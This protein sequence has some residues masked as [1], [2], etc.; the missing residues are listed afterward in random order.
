MAIKDA[1]IA[2]LK[3]EASL[4]KKNAGKSTIRESRLEAT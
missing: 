2:E 4:T 3:H 1:F